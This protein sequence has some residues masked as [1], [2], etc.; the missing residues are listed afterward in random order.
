MQPIFAWRVLTAGGIGANI[1]AGLT[2]MFGGPILAVLLIAAAVA[3]Q[4]I[5]RSRVVRN[6][7]NPD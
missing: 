2:I 5:H 3:A 1:G 4:H 7:S 6:R